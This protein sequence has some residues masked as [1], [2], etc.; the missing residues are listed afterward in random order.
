MPRLS[1]SQFPRMRRESLVV[2]D[3]SDEVLVY[4]KQIDQAH[5]LNLSAARVWRSCDGQ[6]SPAQI[7]R[8]LS[9]QLNAEISEDFV[10]LALNQLEKYQLLEMTE[11]GPAASLERQPQF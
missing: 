11:G 6:T 5:C 3:L 8:K 2:Q 7:G 1:P 4:D 10:L 9:A